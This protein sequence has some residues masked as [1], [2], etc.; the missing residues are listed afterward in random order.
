VL[1]ADAELGRG[2]AVGPTGGAKVLAG[3][4]EGGILRL[5]FLNGFHV[6]GLHKDEAADDGRGGEAGDEGAIRIPEDEVVGMP[7]ADDLL[8]KGG[9]G[10]LVAGAAI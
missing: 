6:G 7:Y 1:V 10:D 8:R 4:E 3:G 5:W 9:G 2:C